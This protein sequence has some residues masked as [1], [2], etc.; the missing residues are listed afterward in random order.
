MPRWPW[1]LGILVGIAASGIAACSQRGP[2]GLA[3]G[4]V[5]ANPSQV[6]AAVD[7]APAGQQGRL[8]ATALPRHYSLE[9]YVDPAKSRFAGRAT[10][11]IDVT[12]PSTVLVIHARDMHIAHV[13]AYVGGRETSAPPE[14]RSVWPGSASDE[15]ELRFPAPLPVGSVRLVIDY[16]APFAS[17]LAGLYRVHEHGLDFAFTQFE[18]SDARR[19][20]P[21]FD[22]PGFKTPYDLVLVTPPAMTAVANAPE[23]SSTVLADGSVAHRFLTTAPIPSYLVAFA[24]GIFDVVQGRTAPFPIRVIAPKGEGSTA[25]SALETAEALVDRL[26]DYFGIS[27]PY[28]KL[29]L[30]AVPDFAPGAMENPGLIAFR[31]GLLLV[32]PLHASTRV[33]RSQATVMAHELAHQWFGDLVTMQWWDDIWLSEGFATWAQAKIVDEWRPHFGAE[34]DQISKVDSVMD[35]DSLAHARSVR[36]PVRSRAEAA[37]AFDGITYEKGAA[38]L[39]M[40]EQWVGPQIF[41]RGVQKYLRDHAWQTA[42]ADDLFAAL[43]YVSTFQ[44]GRMASGF[45][46]HPGVPEVRVNWR[47]DS[48]GRSDLTLRRL[49]WRSVGAALQ[50][51]GQWTVPVCVS[52]ATQHAS[53]CFTLGSETLTR[54]L[55][56]HCPTWVYPNADQSG[57]YRFALGAPQLLA[58]AQDERALPIADRAGLIANAWAEVRSGQIAPS[59]LLEML[60]RFDSDDAPV[61]IEQIVRALA[62]VDRALVEDAA[63]PAFERYVR[64]RLASRKAALGWVPSPG[65]D[66]MVN[67]DRSIE[68]RTVLT[69]MGELAHD[70]ATIAQA[71]AFAVRWLEDPTT[72]SSDTADVAVPLASIGSGAARLRQLRIAAGRATTLDQRELA[73]RAMASFIDPTVLLQ[74]LDV[75]LT[76]EI[77]ASEIRYVLG[78]AL[79]DRMHGA[80][81]LAWAKEHWTDLLKRAPSVL[82]RRFL[83]DAVESLCNA[84]EVEDAA[85]FLEADAGN[86]E[87][88]RRGLDEAIESAK[89]CVAL[90]TR[91]AANLTKWLTR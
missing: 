76:P 23:A 8:P 41:R 26:A 49:D 61:V 11:A 35:L 36:E 14:V 22:E 68:R 81:V 43:D 19:A 75:V 24:V 4:G 27:F 65:I 50:T 2:H 52:D 53:S 18:P 78:S 51:P 82:G 10:I 59:T 87:G 64:E 15:L 66:G 37:E 7:A 58:L 90:H 1:L 45:L 69:A 55:A 20:F 88:I 79:G 71:D 77:R 86:L 85:R 83:V 5:P 62:G 38:V 84:G 3:V 13:V 80:I 70:R 74:A 60:T 56:A 46:D 12:V 40:I 34:L 17:D 16:D 48:H 89:L 73:L 67:D 54:E 47:C 29:D 25:G 28:A 32:D 21:C 39:R 57:Y 42:S 33:R 91:D 31:A 9:I 44:V 6:F 30:V 63:R 72:V